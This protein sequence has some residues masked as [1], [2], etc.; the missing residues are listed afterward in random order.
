MRDNAAVMYCGFINVF[1]C[2]AIALIEVTNLTKRYGAKLAINNI[3]FS[4]K[5]REIL[6]FLGPNGAGKTTTMNIITG[7]LSST[8]GTVTVGGYD[9]LANPIEAKSQIG[10]LPEQP[11]LFMDM[12]VNEYLNILFSLKKIQIP[13]KPHI[14]EVCEQVRI[15]D[16][17]GRLIRNLSKGYRQR[18]GLAQ[19]LL[20]NPSVLILDEPTVGLDPKQIA[21]MRALVRELGKQR[22]LILSSHILQEIQAVC[23]RI[24]IIHHG[25]LVADD[26]P[27]KL[28]RSLS[29]TRRLLIRVKGPR[30]KVSDMLAT[31]SGIRKVEI[32]GSFEENTVDFSL[33]PMDGTDIRSSVFRLLADNDWH[34]FAMRYNDL[35]LEEVF[36]ML[37]SEQVSPFEATLD[38]QAAYSDSK[39]RRS[40]RGDA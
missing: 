28:T 9:V 16:V 29:D 26:E 33:E 22:T 24:I 8:E 18:V 20:G 27:D 40:K 23:D 21:E 39:A 3:S 11:P 10:Y 1:S 19:A 2:E 4:V 7:C 5:N 37:T 14:E 31:V 30:G 17:R 25:T 35:S 38:G 36:L 15:A 13:K 32:V 34:L 12:T 6:G